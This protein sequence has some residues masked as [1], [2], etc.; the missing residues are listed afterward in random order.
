MI[1][2][3]DVSFSYG[4][5]SASIN[6][7]NFDIAAGEFVAIV[8]ENGA[9][10]STT[11]K[12]MNGLLKPNSG[13]V[14][15]DGMD[16]KKTKVSKLAASIGFLFQNPDRQLCCNTVAEEIAF[17]LNL[18]TQLSP[19]EK[20]ARVE[21]MLELFELDGKAN[22]FSMSRGEK[23]RVALASVLVSRPKILILDEPTTGLDYKECT[24]IMDFVKKLNE[25]QGTTVIMVCHDM[26]VV[27]DYAKRVIAMAAGYVVDD[28]PV[29]EVFRREQ[30]VA[31][32]SIVAPQMIAL[33]M[34]L[35]GIFADCNTAEDFTAVLA[36]LKKGKEKA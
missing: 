6:H 33:S 8:G 1:R 26:E 31:K 36:A 9:G 35:G 25:E 27:F 3:D 7:L 17:S 21:H 4:D 18:T 13:T 22:P 2:F 19:E 16:T 20:K 24:I 5:G 34:R 32:A 28:A 11:S 10:K 15:I 12:L 23:Q 14:T 29:G 30:T